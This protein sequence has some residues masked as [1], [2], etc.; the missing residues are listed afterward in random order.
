MKKA[1]LTAL[2]LLTPTFALAH[3]GYQLLPDAL[4]AQ[5]T[6]TSP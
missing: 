6:T 4:V 3:H 1:L 2:V 5:V